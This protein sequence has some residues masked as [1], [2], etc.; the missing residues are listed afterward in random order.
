MM[1]LKSLLDLNKKMASEKPDA[2][3]LWMLVIMVSSVVLSC[4]FLLWLIEK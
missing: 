3:I 2:Y 4:Q 1:I